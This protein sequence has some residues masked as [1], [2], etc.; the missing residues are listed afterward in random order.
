MNPDLLTRDALVQVVEELREGVALIRKRDHK[1]AYVNDAGRAII[2]E[3]GD[4]LRLMLEGGAADLPGVT[5][6]VPLRDRRIEIRSIPVTTTDGEC[7]AVLFRDLTDLR[8]QEDRLTTFSRT[9]AS[10]AFAETLTA[11]LDALARD[12]R[13]TTDMD[14]CTF[15]LMEPDG[16]LRQVGMSGNYPMAADYGERIRACRDL[17]APLLAL[18]AMAERRPMVVSGWRERTLRDPRFAPLHD[19]SRNASWDTIAVIPLVIRGDIVGVFNGF[20]LP[21]RGPSANELAFLSAIA[22]QAA[23]AVD[24]ARLLVELERRA[25]LDERHRLAR[26]LHD[27]V[28]Q[29][30][31]SLT[32]QARAVEVMASEDVPPIDAL[33]AGLAEVRELTRG[34]LAEMRALIFQ[35]RP[36]ALHEEGLVASI[37]RHAAAVA[38]REGIDVRVEGPPT[39]EELSVEEE[40]ELFRVVVEAITNAV[41]HATPTRIVTRFEQDPDGSVTIAVVD[42][43]AGFDTARR[44]PGHLGLTSME[45]RTSRLGGTLEVCSAPGVSTSIRARLPRAS[46]RARKRAQQRAKE[47][48]IHARA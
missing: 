43:G 25:T 20:Y 47:V 16:E 2:H 23:V 17:G 44:H 42:D 29:A 35:L 13:H 12:V 40:S 24:N 22:D 33:R 27:S 4:D 39:L 10:L 19:V 32:L 37:R 1:L 34:A 38:A 14:S 48:T 41:K 26:E 18:Q 31:F 45:E 5:S 15:L 8:R 6:E 28:S 21:G 9:S 3:G 11:G 36:E 30:L 7:L 46:E